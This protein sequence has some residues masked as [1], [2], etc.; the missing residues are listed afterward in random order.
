MILAKVFKIFKLKK[1]KN[2]HTEEIQLICFE[3]IY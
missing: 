2:I 1:E 3:E